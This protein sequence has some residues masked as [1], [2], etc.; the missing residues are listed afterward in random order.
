MI[1]DLIQGI[2]NNNIKSISR[3]ISLIENSDSEYLNLLSE[4]YPLDNKAHR[5]GITGPPG[6]GKST[7]T[8]HLIKYFRAK[9]KKVAVLLVDPT[10][11]YSNGAVLGDRIRM[12][13]Y[14]NDS[15][16]FIRSFATRGSK[17]GLS[18]NMNEI[19]DVFQAADFDIILFET[20]GVGQVEVDVVEQVD[21]VVLTLVPESGDDI[22]LMKAGIIE[23][24]DIFVINKSDR[25]D[26]NKLYKSLKNMLSLIDINHKEEWIPSIIKTIATD[27][28]G[29]NELINI[30]CEHKIKI[31]KNSNLN[32]KINQRYANQVF[33]II[34][35]KLNDEFW[36]KDRKIILKK[37]LD[38][39]LNKRISP[40]RLVDTIIND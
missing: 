2:K 15:N 10:S 5:I 17:G 7:I 16:V 31:Q 30:L 20:V 40:M 39:P 19:A 8:N 33:N 14:Y 22:Q 29:I 32:R 26:A 4:L 11:P 23:I 34:K 27:G 36:Y 28:K 25:K 9:E 18:E 6:A 38:K 13:N 35:N 24:A 12:F 21:S 37:E 1:N 3:A